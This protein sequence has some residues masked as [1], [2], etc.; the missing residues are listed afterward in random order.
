MALPVLDKTWQFDVNNVIA[1]LGS[2][3]A[4]ARSALRTAV[5]DVLI[6]FGSSPWT[7]QGSSNSVTAGMDAVDRWAADANLVW[8]NAGSAHSWIVLR[9]TGIATNFE[10]CMDLIGADANGASAAWVMSPSAGFTGGTTLN[11][12]TATDEVVLT[13]TNWGGTS[14]NAQIVT[15]LMQSTDGQCTRIVICRASTAVAL[16]QFDVPKNPVTGWVNPSCGLAVT[17]NNGNEQPT[18]VVL[19]SSGSG[20]GRG[21]QAGTTS[22]LSFFYAIEGYKGSG[23]MSTLQT[24]AN[25]INAEWPM[26]PTSLVG[27]GGSAGAIAGGRGAMGDVF[28]MWFG[29]TTTIV[30]GDTYPSGASRQFAQFGDVI[31]PWDGSVVTIA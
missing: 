7:V 8:A 13:G 19:N 22:I 30:T 11:R 2:A 27:N 16:L 9:Q 23:S 14:I 3:L 6:G 25:D 18:V 28:D 1:A 12:P 20:T 29:L 26:L 5:K 4:T 15:H 10:L 21:Y 31:L 24:V 17:S